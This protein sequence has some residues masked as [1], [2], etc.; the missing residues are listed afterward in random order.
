ML[1]LNVLKPSVNNMAVRVF[2]TLK[3]RL[4][5]PDALATMVMNIFKKK[6]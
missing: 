6:T 5:V 2:H 1:T 4:N 3:E